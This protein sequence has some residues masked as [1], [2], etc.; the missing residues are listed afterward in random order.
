MNATKFTYLKHIS[1][2]HVLKTEKKTHKT[3]VISDRQ[4]RLVFY[5]FSCCSG[6]LYVYGPFC[7]GALKLDMSTLFTAFFL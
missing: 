2:N 7:H 6:G 5:M 4:L 3:I 1:I